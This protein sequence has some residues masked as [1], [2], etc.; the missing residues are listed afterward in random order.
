[1]LKILNPR[2]IRSFQ[3]EIPKIPSITHGRSRIEPIM[4]HHLSLGTRNWWTLLDKLGMRVIHLNDHSTSTIPAAGIPMRLLDVDVY[5]YDNLTRM[6]L[7]VHWSH[8]LTM[9]GK[10]LQSRKNSKRLFSQPG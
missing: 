10:P 3:D 8:L 6:V 2:V 4:L 7:E 1:M 5:F 9:I